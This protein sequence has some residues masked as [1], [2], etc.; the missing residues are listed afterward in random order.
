VLDKASENAGVSAQHEHKAYD[1]YPT[2]SSAHGLPVLCCGLHPAASR[3]QGGG[4]YRE[5]LVA[6]TGRGRD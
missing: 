3:D 2:Y 4:N 6:G 1:D 5:V